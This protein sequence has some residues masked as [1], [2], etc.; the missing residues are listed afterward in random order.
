MSFGKRPSPNKIINERRRARRGP[1]KINA[2]IV[3]NDGRETQCWIIDV[4][5]TGAQI[6][7]ATVLGIPETFDLRLDTGEC[8]RVVVIR[9][10]A[11]KLGLRI[12][13]P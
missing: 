5:A 4:S 2:T 8:Y 3:H 1:K 13:Q 9:R 7:V 11:G 12:I 6:G 10:A